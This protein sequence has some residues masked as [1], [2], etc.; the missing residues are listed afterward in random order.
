MNDEQENEETRWQQLME[1]SAFNMWRAV[2]VVL[3][4]PLFAFLWLGAWVFYRS[5][6]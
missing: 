4:D 5:Q 3:L 2:A 1:K 6:T